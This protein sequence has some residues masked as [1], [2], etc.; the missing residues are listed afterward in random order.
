MILYVWAVLL[1]IVQY[2]TEQLILESPSDEDGWKR[3]A[4]FWLQIFSVKFTFD[5]AVIP[6]SSEMILKIAFADPHDTIVES[7]TSFFLLF[8]RDVWENW[9]YPD[10]YVI[11]HA[12]AQS[13]VWMH[14]SYAM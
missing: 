12:L 14:S 9:R 1:Y 11:L 5:V 8:E 2:F 13:F 3:T 10:P 7:Y 4:A 6:P